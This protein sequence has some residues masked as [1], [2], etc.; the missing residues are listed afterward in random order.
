MTTTLAVP[1]RRSRRL[2]L[3]IGALALIWGALAACSA[4]GGA[5]GEADEDSLTKVRTASYPSFGMLPVKVASVKGF[6]EANGLDVDDQ[7]GTDLPGWLAGLG[8]QYDVVPTTSSL[9]LSATQRG[10]KN[11]VFSSY[12]AD[13]PDNNNQALVTRTGEGIKTW[14]DMEGRTLGASSLVSPQIDAIKYLMERD[15]GDPSTLKVQ[16]FTPNTFGDQLKAKR[17]DAAVALIP[18][19]YDLEQQGF[20]IGRPVIYDAVSDMLGTELEYLPVGMLAATQSYAKKNPEVLDAIRKSIQESIDWIEDNDAE[21]REILQEWT[22]VSA[23]V[24]KESPVNKFVVDFPLD[25]LETLGKLGQAGGSL[26]GTL[27]DL[28]DYVY[29]PNSN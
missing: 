15:G 1:N 19:L 11:I 10:Q 13:S 21:A 28:A 8:K 16:V 17:I 2:I 23:S 24:A 3:S 25:V 4:S 9:F 20:E 7:S 22:G 29:D 5:D 18:F 6:Y 14:A 12:V 26:E 27:P